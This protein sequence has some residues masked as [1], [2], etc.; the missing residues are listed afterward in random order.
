MCRVWVEHKGKAGSLSSREALPGQNV[1]L[2]R[3]QPHWP[4]LP[5]GKGREAWPSRGPPHPAKSDT[6]AVMTLALKGPG[7]TRG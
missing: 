2:S 4:L 1:N 7:L 5:S 3:P 6:T